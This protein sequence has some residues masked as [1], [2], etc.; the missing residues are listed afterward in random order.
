VTFSRLAI[1]GKFLT[2]QMTGVH[3]V[4]AQ[5]IRQLERHREMLGSQFNS[6]PVVIGPPNVRHSPFETFSVARR[7][8]LRGQLWEQVDLPRIARHDLL[9]NLCNLGP[10]ATSNAITMIHDAQVFIS[11]G[12]YTYPFRTWYRNVLPIIGHRHRRILTVSDFS[13]SQLRL[14]R[15]AEQQDISIVHNGVDHILDYPRNPQIIERLGLNGQRFVVGLA[16]TQAH[17]NIALL[18]SAFSSS[19]LSDLRLVLFGS[20]QRTDFE[21]KGAHVPS[22]VIFAGRLSDGELR[23][24]LEEALCVA[25]PSTTEGFGLPPLE[26]MAVGCPAVLAPC[27]ALPEVAGAAALYA[28]PF[29]PRQWVE[30]IRSLADSTELRMNYAAAGLSRAKQFTWQRAGDV[31]A[32][33]IREIASGNP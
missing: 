4:A 10:I 27:G 14:H 15:I 24:L 31:L 8:H 18:F 29:E 3:R 6:E 33:I 19:T 13:A 7:G 21:L 26:G 9:L 28:S 5:L 20:E 23:S 25:F 30:A 17:K 1:N 22:N 2:A 12:S 32:E 11:P 16:T